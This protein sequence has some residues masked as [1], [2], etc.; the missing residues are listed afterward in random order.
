MDRRSFLVNGLK[1]YL[2][3]FIIDFEANPASSQDTNHHDYFESVFSC[4][5]LLSEAPYDLLVEAANKLG[6][7]TMNKSKLQL[8]KEIFSR[9]DI[10]YGASDQAT[11]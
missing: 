8:A 1:D 10:Y 4:Y 3:E 2:K 6:I 7:S 11:K 5:P 9:E